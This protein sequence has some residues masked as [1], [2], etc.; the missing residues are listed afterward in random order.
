[1]YAIR[2]YYESIDDASSFFSSAGDP[3]FPQDSYNISAERGRSNFDVRHR[4][5]FSY[6]WDLPFGR[7]RRWGNVITS[8]SI[9]YTK[10]YE[11]S[12]SP[13]SIALTS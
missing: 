7:G 3:S 2:S 8:Y 6:S 11:A 10:L 13:E 9:H 4:L 1:M 5:T 12:R